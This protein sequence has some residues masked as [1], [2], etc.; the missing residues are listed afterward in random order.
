MAR[1]PA[2][3][4]TRGILAGSKSSTD[5]RNFYITGM[6]NNSKGI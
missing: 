6:V 5:L 3:I 1:C 4:I 2:K